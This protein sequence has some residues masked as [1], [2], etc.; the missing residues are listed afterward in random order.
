MNIS[1]TPTPRGVKAKEYFEQG[2]NCAQSVAA[3]F[4][5]LTDLPVQTLVRMASPFGGGMGRMREVCGAVSGAL[6]IE[7]L[8][9]GYDDDKAV[10]EKKQLYAEVRSIADA[11]R[12][13]NGSI[14]CRE[15]LSGVPH[16]D[17]G[18]PEERTQAYYQKRPCSE[19][20]LMAASILETHLQNRGIHT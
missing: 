11:F 1:I 5:D 9:C 10:E 17:G 7:G 8:L 16:T 18:T 3:A 15:L 12:A 20:V 2:Y 13:C 4:A 6:L 14:I 19:L